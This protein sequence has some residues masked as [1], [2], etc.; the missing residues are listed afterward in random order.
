VQRR[1][2]ADRRHGHDKVDAATQRWYKLPSR[3]IATSKPFAPRGEATIAEMKASA[4]MRAKL[5][6]VKSLP[7]ATTFVVRSGSRMS[8]P[9]EN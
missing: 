5:K 8:R 6:K 4:L 9:V 7:I 2:I 3:T 1:R